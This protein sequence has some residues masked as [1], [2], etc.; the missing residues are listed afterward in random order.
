MNKNSVS[1]LQGINFSQLI[2]AEKT[3]IKP[4]LKKITLKIKLSPSD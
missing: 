1:Y 2:L 4:S 3:E